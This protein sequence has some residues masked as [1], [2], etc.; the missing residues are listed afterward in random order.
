MRKS[1]LSLIIAGLTL[2]AASAFLSTTP[3]DGET[4]TP[5]SVALADANWGLLAAQSMASIRHQAER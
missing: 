3:A 2:A 5:A 4:K 1:V